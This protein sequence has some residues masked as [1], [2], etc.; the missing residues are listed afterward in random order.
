M[1][2]G[3]YVEV[4]S[5]T[6]CNRFNEE[7]CKRI[8]DENPRLAL[9]LVNSWSGGHPLGCFRSGAHVFFNTYLTATEPC[10]T[11]KVCICKPGKLNMFNES[12]TCLLRSLREIWAEGDN[13]KCWRRAF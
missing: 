2:K 8:A 9:N 12:I 13:T 5:G 10:S 1:I 7:D 6:Q 11:D 3:A 4:T